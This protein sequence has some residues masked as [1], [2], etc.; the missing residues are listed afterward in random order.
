M[1]IVFR[2]ILTKCIETSIFF[3]LNKYN[4]Y[5][6]FS[7]QLYLNYIYFSFDKTRRTIHAFVSLVCIN[8]E[9]NYSGE[10]KS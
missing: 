3:L 6:F 4:K 2:P 8:E 1:R 10:V 7:I 5:F 9:T